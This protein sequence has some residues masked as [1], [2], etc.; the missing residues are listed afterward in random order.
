MG[1]SRSWQSVC[2]FEV[3]RSSGTHQVFMGSGSCDGK[4]LDSNSWMLENEDWVSGQPHQGMNFSMTMPEMNCALSRATMA[5]CYG[6]RLGPCYWSHSQPITNIASYSSHGM[7]S[8][9]NSTNSCTMETRTQGGGRCYWKTSLMKK[10]FGYSQMPIVLK[11]SR[12]CFRA[13]ILS[14]YTFSHSA[15]R[16]TAARPSGLTIG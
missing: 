11:I 5:W 8:Q 4:D 6:Q 14:W 16:E 12:A 10:I 13:V 15:G 3:W 7:T 1:V 9:V 2:C